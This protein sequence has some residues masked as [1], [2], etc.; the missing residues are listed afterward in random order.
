M[1]RL[2]QVLSFFSLRLIA[3]KLRARQ[4]VFFFCERQRESV[5]VRVPP[6]LFLFSPWFP[7]SFPGFPT[8]FIRG[9]ETLKT[10]YAV[11]A[12]LLKEVSTFVALQGTVTSGNLLLYSICLWWTLSRELPRPW[13][14]TLVGSYWEGSAISRIRELSWW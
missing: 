3:S 13:R 10:R 7:F 12:A 5:C 6:S 9:H 2:S 8:A 11:G 1:K 14:R 4:R